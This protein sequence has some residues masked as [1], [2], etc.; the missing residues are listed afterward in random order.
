[1]RVYAVAIALVMT[2]AAVGAQAPAKKGTAA[3]AAN[4]PAGT[5]AQMMRGIYF[6]NANILFDVQSVDPTTPPKEIP[7]DDPR[8]TVMFA[9]IYTGWQVVENAAIAMAESTPLFLTPGRLCQNGKPVPINQ[10]DYR[11]AV[12][13]MRVQ[14][15]KMLEVARSKNLEAASD[16]TNEVA[17][18]CA[19][20]HEVYRDV[21]DADSPNRC[22]PPA[23]AK[24]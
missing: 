1:M 7:K 16:Q 23:A 9:N 19:Q 12:E 14:A 21:G 8:A 3:P 15:L 13:N 10:P 6:P 5:L 22:T 11:A 20:C 4:K 24:K 18:A 17:G 2:T